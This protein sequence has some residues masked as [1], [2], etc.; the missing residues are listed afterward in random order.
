M[1]DLPDEFSEQPANT[2]LSERELEVL[3][4]V[5]A[6][7]SN[8][9]IAEE[10]ILAV[11]TVKTHVHSIIEKLGVSSRTQAVARAVGRAERGRHHPEQVGAERADGGACRDCRDFA[12]RGGLGH[13]ERDVGLGVRTHPGGRLAQGAGRDPRAGDRRVSGG[14]GGE[15]GS[16]RKHAWAGYGLAWLQMLTFTIPFVARNVSVEIR[17][18]M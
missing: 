6:G 13:H 9:Q 10:L 11:G 7:R 3:R 16:C 14:G 18:S 1:S 5:V 2:E 12:R 15:S 8:Q 17:Q 4:L